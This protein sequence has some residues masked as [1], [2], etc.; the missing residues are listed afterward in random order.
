MRSQTPTPKAKRPRT[1][2]QSSRTAVKENSPALTLQT[3]AG[4]SNP[5][6]PMFNYFRDELDEH[7]DCRERVI[8]ASRDVTALS[9]KMIFSLQRFLIPTS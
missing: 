6:L 7:H 2:Y 5:F 8:K 1:S 4:P 3:D 9:K